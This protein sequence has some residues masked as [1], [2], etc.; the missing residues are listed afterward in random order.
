MAAVQSSAMDWPMSR[1][2]KKS[3][4]LR[5]YN[6]DVRAADVMLSSR[7]PALE[8]LREE[9][10]AVR[11]AAGVHK[12][13]QDAPIEEN[14][15]GTTTAAAE[16]EI[17]R[18]RSAV[19]TAAA[20]LRAIVPPPSDESDVAGLPE[21]GST[22]MRARSE[23]SARDAQTSALRPAL[24]RTPRQGPR[25]KRK[26][27]F[28]GQPEEEPGNGNGRPVLTDSDEENSPRKMNATPPR[29]HRDSIGLTKDRTSAEDKLDVDTPVK[30]QVV[31]NT[32]D[33]VSKSSLKVHLIWLL[34]SLTIA[35]IG[36]RWA[37]TTEAPPLT[38]EAPPTN[39]AM[40]FG[41]PA[42]WVGDY[43]PQGCCLGAA[44]GNPRCWDE[45]QGYTFERCCL[46]RA[47]PN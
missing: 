13:V 34:C 23:G 36:G 24:C 41:D 9:L 2:E 11:R 14:K 40:S 39:A 25:P 35:V 45:H 46:G 1:D 37:F 47:I 12:I 22:R 8:A 5:L 26:V 32:G 27:S 28:G 10:D 31:A 16:A 33:L 20:V 6:D 4:L 30:T 21:G 43:T 7:E 15:D 19:E 3:Q 18:L 44:R 38:T 42:C 17:E 29:K